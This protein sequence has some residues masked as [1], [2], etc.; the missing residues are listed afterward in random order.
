MLM[1]IGHNLKTFCE[2]FFSFLVAFYCVIYNPSTNFAFL[3]LAQYI[4]IKNF[5]NTGEV[6][7][8]YCLIGSG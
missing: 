1:A 3:V 7:A 8:L 5:L 6:L 2:G 4:I